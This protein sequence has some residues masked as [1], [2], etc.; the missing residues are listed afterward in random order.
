[1]A[2]RFGWLGDMSILL[3]LRKAWCSGFGLG[4]APVAPGTFGTMVAWPL[5]WV[6]TYWAWQQMCLVWLFLMAMSLWACQL[7]AKAG[8]DPQWIVC[9][10]FMAMWLL[11]WYLPHTWSSWAIATLCFR[12]FDIT[13]IWPIHWLESGLPTAWAIMVD[14]LMAAIYAWGV[15]VWLIRSLGALGLS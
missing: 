8:E 2:R 12:L 7:E 9:D 1:M 14:D 15:S 13:K 5:L 6:S 3:R 11:G 4:F 10:E